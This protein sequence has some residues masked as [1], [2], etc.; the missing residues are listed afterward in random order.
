MMLKI[1]IRWVQVV[2]NDDI[3]FGLRSGY[4]GPFEFAES[5]FADDFWPFLVQVHSVAT[6]T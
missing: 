2:K 5:I 6:S 1:L 3:R 4:I